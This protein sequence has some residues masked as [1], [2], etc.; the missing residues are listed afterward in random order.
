MIV[1]PALSAVLTSVLRIG[2]VV[3]SILVAYAVILFIF[4]RRLIYLPH[5]YPVAP[6]ALLR[7]HLAE[8]RAEVLEFL[9][10]DVVQYAYLLKS[11][12]PSPDAAFCVFFG[13]NASLALDWLDCAELVLP[14]ARGVLLVE[15][16][17]YGQNGGRP[18]RE[19][20]VQTALKAFEQAAERLNTS[21]QQL[22][23]QTHLLGISLGCAVALEFAQRYDVPRIFLMAPFTSL[24]EMARRS[25]G[26]P[27]CYLLLDRFDNV[28]ALSALSQ[29]MPPP[30]IWIFHGDADDVVPVEMSRRM[31]ERFHSFIHY[32]EIPGANHVTV[33]DHAFPL[34]CDVACKHTMSGAPA[35]TVEGALPEDERVSPF[36]NAQ[37]HPLPAGS[38]STS[39]SD[40]TRPESQGR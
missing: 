9:N 30:E 40:E 22:A 10:G 33:L 39:P 38:R 20:I 27:L 14:C 7:E 2:L 36:P 21:S 24:L 3:L 23:R 19:A 17:G 18:S 35:E 11:E 28:A 4:Q 32:A 25:V 26:W 15:Y 5:T 13:G 34:I 31:A 37:N 16:P 1:P 12:H 6:K 8:G 29:R